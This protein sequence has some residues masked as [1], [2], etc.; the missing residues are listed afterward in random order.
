MKSI[1]AIDVELPA[2]FVARPIDPDADSQAITDLS[3]VAAVA[4]YGTPDAT[5]QMVQESYR[6]PSF[7]PATDGR[8]VCDPEGHVAAVVEFYDSDAEHV[9]PF[10]YLRVRPDLLDS[11][12]G[13]GLVAWAES[14]AEANLTLPA[15]DL[16]VAAHTNVA[17]LNVPMQ[18]M[19]E[20]GGWQLERVYRTMEIELDEE[21]PSVPPLPEP[22]TIRTAVAGQD[23]RAV[24]EAEEEA[25]ADHYGF[26]Q[27][28]Y[29]AWLQMFT[30]FFPYDPSLWFL[31]MDGSQIAGISLCRLEAAGRPEVGWVGTLGVRPAWRGR[32]LGLTLLKHSF[33][34]LHRRGKRQV[35]LAVDSQ[36][37][38]GATRLY[39]RAGMHA[40][41]DNR[42]HERVLREGRD[43]R[44]TS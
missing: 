25:F 3:N 6:M 4:E 23:E 10:V 26:V 1:A 41:R 37:L 18:R 43:I 16:R 2:G 24:Y 33:A 28:G 21:A 15:P 36:S 34:E 32:G 20:G 13:Q 38:T 30:K 31:A 29:D 12:V 40:T 14:R 17:A 7:N 11:G 42:G 22:L 27:Q 39:E 19:L 9:A 8:V 5:L 44:T 35:G